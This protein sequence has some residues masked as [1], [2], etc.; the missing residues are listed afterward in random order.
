MHCAFDPQYEET[1]SRAYRSYCEFERDEYA[2]AKNISKPS[3]TTLLINRFPALK[4]GRNN[5]A[6]TIIGIKVTDLYVSGDKV[7]Q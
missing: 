3:F 2:L 7:T 4:R 5:K 1:I 6:R